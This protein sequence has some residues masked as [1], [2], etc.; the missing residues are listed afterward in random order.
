MVAL[1]FDC[2]YCK[3][4]YAAGESREFCV[5]CGASLES[6]RQRMALVLVAAW[7]RYLSSFAACSELFLLLAP[8]RPTDA[9]QAHHLESMQALP[10]A[11]TGVPLCRLGTLSKSGLHTL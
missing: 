5:N 11:D 8:T 3:T 4:G 7:A 10:R 6:P 9:L 1:P 2:E